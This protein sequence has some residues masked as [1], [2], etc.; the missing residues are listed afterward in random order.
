MASFR[1]YCLDK[2]DKIVSGRDIEAPD[3]ETAIQSARNE[4]GRANGKFDRF[5]VWQGA[6]RLFTSGNDGP[7]G[8]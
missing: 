5:E 8:V 3:L 1:F 2:L 6:K 7:V 4:C